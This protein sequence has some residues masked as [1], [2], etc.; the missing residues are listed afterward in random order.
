[1]RRNCKPRAKLGKLPTTGRLKMDVTLVSLNSSSRRTVAQCNSLLPNGGEHRVGA[2]VGRRRGHG[3]RAR[4]R[5]R[6]RGRYTAGRRRASD[7]GGGV[8]TT[9][10]PPTVSV[11]VTT[12][13]VDE[14]SSVDVLVSVVESVEESLPS[15]SPSS[16]LESS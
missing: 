1:M 6:H 12:P 4:A 11:T 5:G 16:V 14:L 3:D 2:G 13:S 9:T 10:G 7:G 15:S 8:V